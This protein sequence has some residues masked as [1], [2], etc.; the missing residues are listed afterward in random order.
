MP[1]AQ[2]L[3]GGYARFRTRKKKFWGTRSMSSTNGIGIYTEHTRILC[4]GNELEC[5]PEIVEAFCTAQH[6]IQSKTRKYSKS[7]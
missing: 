4:L 1:F 2:L 3:S 5:P 6:V 7:P